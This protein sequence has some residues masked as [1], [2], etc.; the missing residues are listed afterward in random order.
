MNEKREAEMNETSRAR[1]D[2]AYVRD[3]VGRSET[4]GAPRA[5]WYLWA[6]IAAVGFTLVDLAPDRVALFWA[7]AAPGGFLASLWLG[8]RH[9]RRSG[10]LSA[11]GG[12]EH[13]LH[14]GAL[15]VAVFLLVPLATSGALPGDALGQTILL[16]IGL[17]YFLAGVHLY[18]PLAWI[19]LLMAVGYGL[20]F[21]VDRWAWTGIGLLVGLGLVVTARAGERDDG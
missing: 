17:G 6:A 8:R 2:L 19:G 5:I 7:V 11:R 16:V 13:A 3:V 15:L 18:R 1:D 4:Y 12:K 14:W 9:G 21:F 20:L 10:Q